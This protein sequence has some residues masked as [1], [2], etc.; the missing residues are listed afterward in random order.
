MRNMQAIKTKIRA[1]TE[2]WRAE[3]ERSRNV[4]VILFHPVRILIALICE[5]DKSKKNAKVYDFK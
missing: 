4:L 5:V 3:N 1:W 2:V